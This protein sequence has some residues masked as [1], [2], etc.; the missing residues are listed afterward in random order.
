MNFSLWDHIFPSDEGG[1]EGMKALGGSQSKGIV[2]FKWTSH[3]TLDKN[4]YISYV[5]MWIDVS[6]CAYEF[7]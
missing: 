6:V 3:S 4:V 7:A 5:F 1:E 2:S